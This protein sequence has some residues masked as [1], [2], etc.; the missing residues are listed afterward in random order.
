MEGSISNLRLD[1]KTI[2]QEIKVLQ[3]LRNRH[4]IQLYRT[5]E[6]GDCIYLLMELAEKGSLAHAINKGKIAHDDWTTKKRLV[7]EIV[8][9][10]PYIHQEKVLHRDLKSANIL[11]TKNME[12]R[13]ADF[14]LAQIRSAVSA[15]S[16]SG[17][18]STSKRPVG[19][20]R[21]VAPELLFVTKPEYSTKSDAW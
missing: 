10:L 15:A 5:Y 2:Q 9:G 21:W 17:H 16:S 12:V 11:L 13:L 14:G 6:D 19:T 1:Q 7:H 18:Q 8:C 4:I 3:N 20:L